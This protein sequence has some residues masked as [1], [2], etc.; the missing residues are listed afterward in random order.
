MYQEN[1]GKAMEIII[2]CT[3]FGTSIVNVILSYLEL[4]EDGP[5]SKIFN[6]FDYVVCCVFLISYSLKCY[7]AT[8]RL[9][10]IFSLMSFL[11]LFILLPT[12][13]I[14]NSNDS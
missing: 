4:N 5:Y 3:A 6:N 14:I 1:F 2:G 11:D 12:L 8:H 9:Q 10:Y 13:I 7:V